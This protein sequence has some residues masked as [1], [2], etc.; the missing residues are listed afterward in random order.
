MAVITNNRAMTSSTIQN[1]RGL[2]VA[3]RVLF[4]VWIAKIAE[5]FFGRINPGLILLGRNGIDNSEENVVES[6]NDGSKED[7]PNTISIASIPS[8]CK[9][10]KSGG[11]ITSK[12]KC[13]TALQAEW[14][15]RWWKIHPRDKTWWWLG[16]IIITKWTWWWCD[17]WAWEW[18]MVVGMAAFTTTMV[19]TG[20]WTTSTKLW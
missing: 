1:R 2:R 16:T 4:I 18:K 19:E 14:T 15:G 8:C 13:G 10:H 6:I 9:P 5:F 12:W 20:W 3:L 11:K 7:I 17:P